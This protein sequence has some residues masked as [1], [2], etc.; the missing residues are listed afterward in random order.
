MAANKPAPTSQNPALT[1]QWG[2]LNKHLLGEIFKLK[3]DGQLWVR[4][5]D[6]PAVICGVTDASLD[7]ALNWQSPFEN[8]GTES[9]APALLAMLQ[10]GALQPMVDAI[11]K[12]SAE[13][14]EARRKSDTF[15]SQFEGRT[16]ITKL[17]STQ[18]FNGMQPMKITATLVFRAWRDAVAEV[19]RPMAQ[20][21]DWILPQAL[22]RDGSVL[23]RAAETARGESSYVQML[24]PSLA[25]VPVSFRYKGRTFT[26][27]VVETVQQNLDSPIDY[28]GNFVSMKLP[29]TLT[30]LTAIDRTDWKAYG[31]L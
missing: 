29:V 12:P 28:Q 26:E 4:D 24:M 9:Q 22:S 30:S 10:T 15:L 31:P 21:M 20:L 14:V 19:E 18:V 2:Q 17:N 25:P 1:S 8:S 27:L 7:L 16:G 6:S 5:P 23:G 13:T 11:F 3:K